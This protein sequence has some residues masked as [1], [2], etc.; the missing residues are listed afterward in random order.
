M[1]RLSI[2]LVTG[3][4]ALG[5]LFPTNTNAMTYTVEWDTTTIA[6]PRWIN[7][8]TIKRCS[9]CE[10]ETLRQF[11][12]TSTKCEQQYDVGFNALVC[13]H[14]YGDSWTHT[15]T[16]DWKSESFEN[17]S[18]NNSNITNISDFS[19]I[20][21][22]T[23]IYI[24][25]NETLTSFNSNIFFQNLGAQNIHLENNYIS[26]FE[27]NIP[28]NVRRLYLNSN[29][30][31]TIPENV[32]KKRDNYT[33]KLSSS[34]KFPT[35]GS[36]SYLIDLSNNKI[37]FVQI[38][39]IDGVNESNFSERFRN[40]TNYNFEW[41]W[42]SYLNEDNPNFSYSI[43]D[44][45]NNP[46]TAGETTQS[47]VSINASLAPW[48]YTFKVSLW[49]AE[50]SIPFNV[51]YYDSL[52]WV[53]TNPDD[54]STISSL[55]GISFSWKR[56]WDYPAD[57]V[58]WYNYKLTKNSTI[59]HAGSAPDGTATYNLDKT[60]IQNNPNWYYEFTVYLTDTN[61]NTIS[62]VDPITTTFNI[63][64]DNTITLTSPTST[65]FW[66]RTNY[67]D[68]NFEWN[69]SSPMFD[70]YNYYVTTDNS[71]SSSNII[72]WSESSNRHIVFNKLLEKWDYLLCIDMYGSNGNKI[73]DR[74][75]SFSVEIPA[76]ISITAPSSTV[77]VQPIQFTWDS[78]LPSLYYTFNNYTYTV[79]RWTENI[80]TGTIIDENE[81][82]FS[83]NNLRDGT[84][85][86][87]VIMNH[88]GGST[89]DTKTFTVNSSAGVYLNL[90]PNDWETF[91]WDYIRQ[92][93]VS[94]SWEWWWSSLIS[95]YTYKLTKTDTSEIRD[96]GTKNST[97]TL[98]LWT[99][100][101][102]SGSYRFEVVML[103]SDDHEITNSYSDFTVII[104]SDLQI[105]SPLPWLSATK[106]ITFSRSWFDEFG[107]HYSYL[108][109]KI[110]DSW[111]ETLITSNDLTT[112]NS[113]TMPN[114]LNGT[115]TFSVTLID[116]Y[117][118]PVITKSVTFTIPDSQELTISISDW[119]NSVTTLRSKT[120]IFSRWW[121]SENFYSY[122]YSVEWTTI[123]NQHYYYTWT[124]RSTAWNFTLN[125]LSTWRYRF[126]VTMLDSNSNVITWK[127]LDFNVSIPASLQI[128]SPTNWAKITTSNTTFTWAWYSDT[129][130]KYEYKLTGQPAEST[131]S[132]SFTTN[133]TNGNYTLTVKLY[134]WN[135][136]VAQDSIDFTV[137]VPSTPTNPSTWGWW[138]GGGSS[139]GWGSS[140]K[141]HYNNNLKVS[142]WNDSPITNE[143]IDLIV[144]ID[145]KYTWKV[146]FPKLQYY[147][148]D[149][150]K[151]IDIPVTSKNYVSDYSDEAKLWYIKFTSDDDWRIDVSQFIKFSK[152]W[153]YRIYAEDK[154]WYDEYVEIYVSNKKT[155]A[156]NNNTNNTNTN[157]TTNNPTTNNN[158]NANSIIR[159]YLPEI[160]EAK[161]TQEEVYVARSCKRYTIT[162][163]DSLN[164]YTSPNLNISEY[165]VSKDYFKR[166]ID[167][168]NKY[169]SGCPTNVW[170]ISTNYS[171]KS[172][173]NSRYTAPN[174]KVYFI[175]W[176]DWNY[177][178]NELNKE[179]KTPT[180]FK[181]IQELKYYIR[182]RNPLIS[183]AALWPTN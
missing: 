141:T 169:Q 86:V 180:S 173:D 91:N 166:Y 103:D 52:T 34:K 144:K 15:V 174:G 106:D 30:L 84:Y 113:F 80:S 148:P 125:D 78:F 171:D 73:K 112:S 12:W 97:D 65:Q 139:S 57:F 4:I 26:S 135:T 67:V 76:I 35:N 22:I 46:V 31:T 126:T 55:D 153:Y 100:Y 146:T 151:W 134:S 69:T 138:G 162:Y 137:N 143:R 42:Y 87:Q 53:S 170:W 120:W 168:K 181:T 64:I 123:K 130:T 179:L 164:V 172:N 39:K 142:L 121:S 8:T 48:N 183:M 82:S 61:W 99:K 24:E 104:P 107:E 81:R 19:T 145:D 155:V 20:N 10:E 160:F 98:S 118:E 72:T 152:N 13:S 1:K 70:H 93:P 14:Y 59:I 132:T 21:D 9:E 37:E 43:I 116:I 114:L 115:Y 36:E 111:N 18:L 154:D 89:G 45:S 117:D 17:F 110:D 29:Q 41:F 2:S 102:P 63:E 33:I 156:T 119:Q 90:T 161:D 105:K 28:N 129:I 51:G 95:K 165:F 124:S 140:W 56:D 158:T 178:S 101:L 74:N 88:S 47:N 44:S 163:S 54:S 75:Q 182:D 96:S 131:T 92:V 77:S 177:Y 176:R 167:S 127:Y 79:K 16:Y 38:T 50:D 62:R 128:T 122:S 85:S 7:W 60:L 5:L 157:I 150:E 136:V 94:L 109:K 68:V 175:T 58:S 83:L 49:D 40:S 147:S 6:I 108:L 149:T 3:L 159:E 71:C 25:N 66:Y 27:G 23:N 133:L 32:W 11:S